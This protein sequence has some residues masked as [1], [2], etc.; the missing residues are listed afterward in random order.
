MKIMTS[1]PPRIRIED[2]DVDVALP[3]AEFDQRVREL[4]SDDVSKNLP[5]KVDRIVYWRGELPR[6]RLWLERL[7]WAL[8]TGIGLVFLYGL[9]ALARKGLAYIAG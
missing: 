2:E 3:P 8:G 1:E 6:R 7:W 5:S 9:Y 4:L